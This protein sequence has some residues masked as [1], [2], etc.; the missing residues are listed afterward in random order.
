MLILIKNLIRKSIGGFIVILLGAG[1]SKPFGIPTMQEL[2][3]KTMNLLMSYDT[4]LANRIQD[5]LVAAGFILDFE[6][7]YT[8]VEALINPTKG[9]KEAGPYAAFLLGDYRHQIKRD[10]LNEILLQLRKMIYNECEINRE[11]MNQEMVMV[12]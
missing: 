5:N 11:K 4:P 7:I 1:A 8:I 2:T 9:M 3:E 12:F 6:N 10:D